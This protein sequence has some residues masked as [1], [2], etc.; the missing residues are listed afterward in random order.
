[1]PITSSLAACAA[2]IGGFS[3]EP[4]G[5]SPQPTASPR[6]CSWPTGQYRDSPRR[7]RAA[8]RYHLHQQPRWCAPAEP[9]TRQTD[10]TVPFWGVF[11]GI[12][13]QGFSL[14][15][16]AFVSSCVLTALPGG[17]APSRSSA[18]LA[19]SRRSRRF[20]RAPRAPTATC[21][22]AATLYLNTAIRVAALATT[23]DGKVN[24]DTLVF[25]HTTR[26]ITA[27]PF[28]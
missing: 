2:P 3:R 19:T 1:V 20:S 17:P 10:Y 13:A 23:N 24:Y 26:G 27:G 18:M 5:P 22:H 28:S 7:G 16:A 21:N 11:G 6:G 14:S 12:G 15:R 8:R 4:L 25:F 9:N